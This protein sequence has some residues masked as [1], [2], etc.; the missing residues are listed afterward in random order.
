MTENLLLKKNNLFFTH[1]F[2]WSNLTG[3]ESQ[4]PLSFLPGPIL[5]TSVVFVFDLI[6]LAD[7]VVEQD[8][9]KLAINLVKKIFIEKSI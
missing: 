3:G 4:V 8:L 2:V 7:I 6:S 9:S 5:A 1:L